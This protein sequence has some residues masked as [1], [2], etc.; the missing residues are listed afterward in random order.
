[1][2]FRFLLFILVLPLLCRSA[3]ILTDS[4]PIL[5]PNSTGPFESLRVDSNKRRLLLAHTGNGTLDIIDL[6]TETLLKQISTGSA[7]D[8]AI[9]AR[10]GNYYVSVSREKKLV[11]IS[12][13]TLDVTKEI[14]LPG[15]A[16]GICVAPEGV[17]RVFVGDK[18]GP[19]LWVVDPDEGSVVSTLPIPR[20]SQSLLSEDDTSRIYQ[21]IASD[22]TVLV[23][24]AADFNTT[25]GGAWS[26]SPAKQ[27]HGFILDMRKPRRMFVAGTNA[28]LVAM[29]AEGNVMRSANIATNVHQIAFDP[30]KNRLYCP[31]PNGVMTVLDTSNGSLSEIGRF[32]IAE[33]VKTA[34]VDPVTSAVW[35]AYAANG[36]C[37]AR[38]YVL[39]K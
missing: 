11:V 24:S 5:I 16:N 35:L 14:F 32:E 37:Y 15:A 7:Q 33:G 18:S 30:G 28:K 34:A 31:G 6:K 38:K 29:N 23:V 19:N 21:T 12:R 1:V 17:K 2:K 3:E 26:T 10:K 36:K 13:D 39:A 4:E 22:S 8:C 25:V 9:D 20:G 27:P